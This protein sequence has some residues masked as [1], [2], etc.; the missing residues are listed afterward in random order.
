MLSLTKEGRFTYMNPLNP[1]IKIFEP[2]DMW[3][4]I[5]QF[6]DLVRKTTNE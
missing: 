3:E 1:K 2:E 5:L 4:K 6:R